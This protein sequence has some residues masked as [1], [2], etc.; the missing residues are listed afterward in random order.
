MSAN[1]LLR[2]DDTYAYDFTTP[3]NQAYGSDSQKD[4]SSGVWGLFAADGDASGAID[5]NDKDNWMIKAGLSGYLS[6][7][8]DMNGQ[9]ANPDKN[10]K[11]VPNVGKQSHIPQ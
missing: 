1:A 5:E 9:V 7:D 10:D 4:L 8:Y 6:E 2:T 11:W 3:A